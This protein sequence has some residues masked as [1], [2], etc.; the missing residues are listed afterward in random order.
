MA[1][2]RG[3]ADNVSVIVIEVI[4]SAQSPLPETDAMTFPAET[5]D[6]RTAEDEWLD[7]FQS[8]AKAE[9]EQI[10]PASVHSPP[11][12]KV[13]YGIMVA[14]A[15]VALVIILFATKD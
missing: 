11:N 10:A 7:R 4:E 2:D 15:I 8:R 1:N 3:G 5:E 9:S 14:F 12:K 13:V 6:Q